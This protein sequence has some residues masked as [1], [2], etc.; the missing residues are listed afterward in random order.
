MDFKA[1]LNKQIII[2]PG[3]DLDLLV[4]HFLHAIK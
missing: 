3:R 4:I 2:F 1:V